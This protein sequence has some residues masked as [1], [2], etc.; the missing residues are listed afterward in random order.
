MNYPIKK[1]MLATALS[2]ALPFTASANIVITEYVEGSSNN[3]AVEISNLGSSS[4]D[5]GAQGYALSLY[6]NGSSEESSDRK[7]EFSGTLAPNASFVVYNESADAEFP[8]YRTGT[9]LPRIP[10]RQ[11]GQDGS[12]CFSAVD[13]SSTAVRLGR[14]DAAD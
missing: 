4:V 1:T 5:L 9:E 8:E 13:T 6:T 7:I 11:T 10:D 3:K 2:C 14:S 12:P